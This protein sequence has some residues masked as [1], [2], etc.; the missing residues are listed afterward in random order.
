MTR[1]VA[2]FLFLGLLIGCGSIPQEVPSLETQAIV[3]SWSPQNAH[4]S[5]TN[6]SE[7]AGKATGSCTINTSSGTGWVEAWVVIQRQSSNG[8]YSDIAQQSP[9]RK[10][11]AAGV[12]TTWS[13]TELRAFTSCIAGTYRTAVRSRSSAPF[14]LGP[15]ITTGNPVYITCST[16]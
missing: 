11:V 2:S 10:A 9:V 15:A 7:I 6:P 5:T 8:S 16:Y 13:N 4:R 3:C 1:F 14:T 12:T